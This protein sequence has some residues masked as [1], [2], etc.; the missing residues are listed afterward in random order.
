MKTKTNNY[1]E[2]IVIEGAERYIEQENAQ[3]TSRVLDGSRDN[4]YYAEYVGY[5][6]IDGV[7]VKAIYLIDQDESH[8][9]DEG[10]YDWDK[11]LAN[12]RIIVDND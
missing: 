3:P 11:A 8:I 7:A 1:G 2:E 6:V 12:G 10:D 5:G 4:G 9:E